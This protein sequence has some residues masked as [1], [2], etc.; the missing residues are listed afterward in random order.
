VKALLLGSAAVVL[1]VVVALPLV[2][3]VAGS[4][5]G[6]A[7]PTLEF[8]RATF[9]NPDNY[10]VLLNTLLIGGAVAVASALL[11]VPLAWLVA[12][13]DMPARRAVW[14]LV[15]VAY[16]T[17][18]FLTA[19]AYV[20]LLGPNAGLVNRALRAGLGL[21]EPP[22]D[23][24]TVTGM[25][26]VI[27][28][29]VFP[30]VFLMVAGALESL[31][32]ALEQSAQILGAGRLRTLGF[33]TLPMV[34]PAILAGTLLAFVDSL[35]L[36]G[37][38]AILG[39]PARIHTIPTKIYGLFSYPPRFGL[40][41]ALAMSLVVVTVASL[42]LQHRFL[43]RRSYVTMTG[44]GAEITRVRLGWWRVPAL[45]LCA[46]VFLVAVVL[47]YGIL[48]G[49]SLSRQWATVL[50]SGNLTLRNYA[51]VLFEFSLT[52]HS[53]ANSLGLA[54]GAATLAM[55]VGTLIAYLDLRTAVPGRRLLDT[56]S[57]VPLGLP[58]I[59]L[60]VGLIQAWIRPP[61]VLYGTVW[62]LLVAYVARFVPFAVRAANS[63]LRQVD[64]ALEEAAR[65]T[66]A[67][68]LAALVTVTLPLIKRGMLS[69]W[70]LI[71]VPALRELSASVLLFTA[72]TETLAVAIFQLYEEGYFEAVCALAVVTLAITVVMLALARWV[73]GPSVWELPARR[74]AAG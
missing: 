63:S 28:L 40:A 36:F 62:I 21:A 29:H 71:F 54:A 61:L 57:L 27:T 39:V 22:F 50:E 64:P 31:D 12:R 45:A 18:P 38:Q 46:A 72:G 3:L 32:P 10:R 68:W 4:L 33:V 52:R 15:N 74:A 58:G 59:V 14:T 24:F 5:L 49:V 73:A 53:I 26:F 25:V 51:Y 65:I 17:P 7:G 37:P 19:I 67:P 34:R 41:S 55:A 16:A 6:P 23:I 13:S 48:V 20:M 70:L 42:W 2:W 9:T 60:S 66:G 11:G 43:Q 69:G 47:P 1:V 56:L 44:K 30:F 35:S 8:Y